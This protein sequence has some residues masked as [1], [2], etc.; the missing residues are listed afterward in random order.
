MSEGASSPL[1]PVFSRDPSLLARIQV[2]VIS[3]YVFFLT[4]FLPPTDGQ[5]RHVK[6]GEPFVFNAREDLHRWNQKRYEALGEV[7]RVGFP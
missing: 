6:T 5:L 4:D 1:C 3:T 7:T 2:S